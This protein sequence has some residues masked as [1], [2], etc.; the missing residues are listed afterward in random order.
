MTLH[1]ERQ[2]KS[3]A[4]HRSYRRAFSTLGF[5]EADLGEAFALAARYGLD[6]VELRVLE[7]SLDLPQYFADRFGTPAALAA[8]VAQ[9]GWRVVSLDTSVR[10]LTAT[11]AERESLLA[12][13]PWAEA[14]GAPYLRVFDGGTTASFEEIAK[15][16]ENMRWWREQRS[17]HGWRTDL[18]V[19]THDALV[20]TASL[21]R[22]LE[23]VPDAAILWDS[24]HT[25][26]QGR[27]HPVDTWRS[28]RSNVVHI[29][30]KD[31]LA[32][33]GQEAHPSHVLPG[34]GEFPMNSLLAV[35]EREFQGV[36]SLEWEKYW[37]PALPPLELALASAGRLDWW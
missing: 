32:R 16:A 7:R 10:L 24:H 33:V 2:P 18:M 8:R 15:A 26:Y 3:A 13:V 1:P 29:H 23:A 6:G 37:I 11:P 5:P 20:T 9:E 22:L 28:I 31:S 19:E 17:N 14:C 25:W 4:T 35:L 36:I 21:R 12:F 34:V 27:E 30:V